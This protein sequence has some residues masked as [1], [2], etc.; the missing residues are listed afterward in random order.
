MQR[1]KYDIKQRQMSSQVFISPIFGEITSRHD[2]R[3]DPGKLKDLMEMPPKYK[4]GP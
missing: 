4:K 3:P 2:A 1:S